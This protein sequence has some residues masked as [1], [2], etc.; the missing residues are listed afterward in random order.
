MESSL[1]LT[2]SDVTGV[3][4]AG[5]KSRRMGR[6]KRFLEL[7]G[8]TF[9]ERT[10]VVFEQLFSEILVVVAEPIDRPTQTEHRIVCDLYPNRGSLGGLYTGLFY[11][12]HRRVFT[13]ACD[14][15]F[16]DP[17]AV[18]FM[19]ALDHHHHAD[20]VIAQ[21]ATG[22]QP[23]H[24]LYSKDCLPHLQHMIEAG[25]LRLHQL[26]QAPGLSTR[27]IS[28]DEMRSVDPQLL[29]FFNVNRPAD[30]QFAHKV[31]QRRT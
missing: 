28:E 29:S 8:K 12:A 22:L 17:A 31:H 15:P 9:L 18:T 4:L 20:I 6:D 25:D 11:A 30:L 5:G 19:A 2:L 3:L 10:L 24:A 14:M 27:L 1:K 26:V 16:L 23:M 21:L 7:G 13:A